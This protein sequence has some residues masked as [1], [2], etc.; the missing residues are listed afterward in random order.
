MKIGYFFRRQFKN[1]RQQTRYLSRRW[2]V[3]I[4]DGFMVAISWYLS[5]WLRFNLGIVPDVFLKEAATLLPIIIIVHLLTSIVL[6]VPRGAWRFTSLYDLTKVVQAVVFGIAITAALIFAYDRMWAVPRAVFLIHTILLIGLLVGPRIVLRIWNDRGLR[7][8]V[9][10]ETEKVLV[11]GAGAAGEMLIRDLLRST[12][13]RYEP[14]ALVDDDPIKQGSEIQGIRVIGGSNT[15]PLLAKRIGFGRILLA[16]PSATADQMRTV[17]TW[18]EKAQVPFRTLPKVQDIIDGTATIHDL[19]EVDLDDLLGRKAVSLNW[20]VINTELESKRIVITG[21]GGSIGSELCRQLVRLK[22]AQILLIDQSEFNLYS[23]ARELSI[24]EKNLDIRVL[25]ADVCDET[26]IQH[27]F[28]LYR[29]EI[30]FHAAAYKHVPLLQQQVREAVRNNVI[31]TQ[32][33]AEAS[34]IAR[35]KT[36]V[37]ISTDKAV[38]PTSLMGASKRMAEAVCQAFHKTSDTCFVTVRFGNVLGSTGSVVPLFRKQIE[39]GGPVTVTHPDM[40][41]YFMT[42]SEACQLILQASVAGNGQA[43]YLLDMGEPIKI[44]DLAEQ[45]IRLAGL[46]LEKD[47]QIEFTGL[48]PGEKLEEQLFHDLESLSPTEFDKLLLVENREVDHQNLIRICNQLNLACNEYDEGAIQRIL[49][50]IV[51]EYAT[52]ITGDF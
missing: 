49:K 19:R 8:E 3:F 25:L 23:I 51:P 39:S 36:F 26:A 48:R 27:I 29:P 10:E 22:P 46:R 34:V 42:M 52:E 11:V 13:R 43:I 9:S 38:N 31:G 16:M 2:P 18:C 1:I 33:V 32:I 6:G 35:C 45:M 14:V 21:A 37:L 15:I 44:S 12:P 5:Y 30:V 28:T 7:S 17:V 50:D 24:H 47:I 40:T 4:H 20:D 41:R